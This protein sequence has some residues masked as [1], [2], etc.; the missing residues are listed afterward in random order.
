MRRRVVGFVAALVLAVVGTIMLVAYV[1]GAEDR[2]LEGEEVVEVL[3]V[4]ER[5]REGAR[6][7]DIAGSVRTERVKTKVVIDD[8]VA[9]L[10]DLEDLVASVDLFPG[11][12]LSRRRFVTP[13]QLSLFQESTVEVPEGLLEVTIGVDPERALGGLTDL[14]GKT[15][16]V[17]A[18]FDPFEFTVPE[19]LDGPPVLVEIDGRLVP[20]TGKTPSV[21]QTILHDV[22]VTNVDFDDAPEPPENDDDDNSGPLLIDAP[23]GSVLVTLALDL[24]G[25]ER[26]VFTQEFGRVWLALETPD[27]PDEPSGLVDRGNI[28]QITA[29]PLEIGP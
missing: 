17:V 9:D 5:I 10:E 22:L 1:G 18:S 12:Q 14:E 24:E 13:E 16:A 27:D 7:E 8:A 20:N 25:V 2:A 19:T 15:V 29:P 21:T 6:A 4:D 28:F 23:N 26:L 3:V 11:E